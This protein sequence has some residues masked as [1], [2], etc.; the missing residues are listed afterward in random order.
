[1]HDNTNCIN[2]VARVSHVLQ[3]RAPQAHVSMTAL[4]GHHT[5]PRSAQPSTRTQRL[6]H[7]S[8]GGFAP[9]FKVIKILS[10]KG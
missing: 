5:Q 7:K 3:S 8:A 2:L 10:G 4:L 6:L 1:M 9:R